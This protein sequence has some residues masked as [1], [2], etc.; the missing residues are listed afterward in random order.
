MATTSKVVVT[1][2]SISSIR[3]ALYIYES[4]HESLPWIIF[5]DGPPEIKGLS[6]IS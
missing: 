4:Y 5:P 6:P 1:S 3:F 2:I